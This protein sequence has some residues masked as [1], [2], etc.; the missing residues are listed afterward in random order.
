MNTFEQGL[1]TYLSKERLETIQSKHIGIA[2]AGGLGSNA[3]LMLTRCGFRKFTLLDFDTIEPANLNRQQYTLEDI[4][5]LKVHCLVKK[6]N[7]INP[8]AVC[9]AL[10][11]RWRPDL[12]DDPFL[13]C[14]ILVEAF[15]Q[16]ESKTALLNHYSD[17]IRHLVSGNGMAGIS[18]PALS[19]KKC[20]NIFIVGDEQTEAGRDHPPMAPRVTACAAIMSEIIL[21]LTLDSNFSF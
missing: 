8:D 10:N 2:G 9:T 18:G 1:L 16:P 11:I 7:A 3:A 21:Q 20:G 17:K 15:D 13:S 12:Q 5:K 6:I 19:I 14:D 4:G